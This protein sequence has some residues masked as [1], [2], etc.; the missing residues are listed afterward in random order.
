MWLHNADSLLFLTP[1]VIYRISR[2][3][4][5][6]INPG[7]SMA[8]IHLITPNNKI[9]TRALLH[10]VG[11]AGSQAEL[12]D[13]MR[14]IVAILL[15]YWGD[16]NP[17]MSPEVSDVFDVVTSEDFYMKGILKTV[18]G[19][20]ER[21]WFCSYAGFEKVTSQWANEKAKGCHGVV[22]MRLH[23]TDTR[24]NEADAHTIQIYF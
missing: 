13:N 21:L 10:G 12:R 1:R 15:A 22:S 2:H 18:R 14:L 17:E 8:F 20:D 5:A 3:E 7:I 16:T 6:F 4:S 19:T 9:Y 24:H 23:N 11:Y